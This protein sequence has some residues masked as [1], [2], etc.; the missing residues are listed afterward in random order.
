MGAYRLINTQ[1]LVLARLNRIVR[2][3]RALSRDRHFNIEHRVER[4]LADPRNRVI[5]AQRNP[6]A[7]AMN[8]S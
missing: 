7:I 6:S 5:A 1:T 8:G 4:V 3:S 2:R